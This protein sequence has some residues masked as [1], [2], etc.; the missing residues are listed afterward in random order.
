MAK[1]YPPYI[2]G[3]I[4]AFTGATIVVPFSLNRANSLSDIAGFSLRIKT[5]Q[6]NIMLAT[7]KQTDIKY[8]D[9]Y[10]DFKVSFTL[11]EDL[12]ELLNIGQFYKLQ[13]AFINADGEI[14]YYSTVGIIKYTTAPVVTIANLKRQ[15]NTNII[16]T[17]NRHIYNYTG[18]YS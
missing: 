14:G 15:D 17:I 7:L 12:I 8:Y 11:E 5:V 16:S 9:I 18:T 3:T 13:L 4:P 2:E 1:L 10:T 6:N